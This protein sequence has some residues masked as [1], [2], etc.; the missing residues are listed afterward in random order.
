M[1]EFTYK[2]YGY[3]NRGPEH[4]V[5]QDAFTYK[6]A[7]FNG[8]PIIFALVADGMGGTSE[9]EEASNEIKEAFENWFANDLKEAM[10]NIEMGKTSLEEELESWQTIIEQVNRSLNSRPVAYDEEGYPKAK[11]GTTLVA[12][13]LYAGRY[14]TAQIGDSRIYKK[15]CGEVVVITKDHSWVQREID[16]GADIEDLKDSPHLHSLIRC[17]G[18][19]LSDSPQVDYRA[20][21]YGDDC[22]FLLCSDGFW[23][24]NQSN[25]DVLE[26]LSNNE[27]DTKEAVKRFIKYA[28][29]REEMD[30]IT[31]VIIKTHREEDFKCDV[32]EQLVAR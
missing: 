9:G 25:P 13:L 24:T 14:Y 7:S 6:G 3:T 19:G 16:K 22:G 15:E 5:N 31:A 30:D 32:T 18:A 2:V 12:I 20:G 28:R 8:E 10:E 1:S 11:P 27:I 23:Q 17:I 29:D 26:T 21:R 4:I